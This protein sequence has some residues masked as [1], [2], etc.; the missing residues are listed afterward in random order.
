M[1]KIKETLFAVLIG[2]IGAVLVVV[3]ILCASVQ[4]NGQLDQMRME[5]TYN[6]ND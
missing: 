6:A 3:L 5:E 2:T 4:R 1:K